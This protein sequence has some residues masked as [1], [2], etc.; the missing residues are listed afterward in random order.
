MR[1]AL[2]GSFSIGKTTLAQALRKSVSVR[3]GAGEVHLIEETAR[4]VIAAGFRLD[5][6]GTLEAYLAYVSMQLEA[7]R[8]ATARHVIADRSLADLLAY[9]R[10]NADPKI[11]VS[12]TTALEEIVRLES[13][14]F[15]W[16]CYIPIE[17]PLV[18]DDV[19]PDDSSYQRAVDENYRGV[20][21]EFQIPFVE[22]RGTLAQ[23]AE[24]LSPLFGI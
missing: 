21:R 3:L 18:V 5:R 7:E 16:H 22:V 8:Q 19:R 12:F 15:D 4:K 14:Y 2:S 1:I 10:T 6:H 11:P 17:F 23:R 20:L 9:V 13:R 24:Q